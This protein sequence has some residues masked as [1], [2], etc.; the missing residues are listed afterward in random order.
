MPRII[1]KDFDINILK[2]ELNQVFKNIRSV[3]K[4]LTYI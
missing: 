2:L 4:Y 3:W 1:D